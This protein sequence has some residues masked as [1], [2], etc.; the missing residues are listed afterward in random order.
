MAEEKEKKVNL[1]FKVSQEM[2][3]LLD[4][5]VVFKT[6]TENKKSSQHAVL[7]EALVELLKK[8]NTKLNPNG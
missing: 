6:V 1:N 8:Y 3:S 5:L 2:K 7:E 4:Q